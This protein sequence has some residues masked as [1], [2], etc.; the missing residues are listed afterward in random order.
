M[1][2]RS[3]QDTHTTHAHSRTT[4]DSN[5]PPRPLAGPLPRL[6]FYVHLPM[7]TFSVTMTGGSVHPASPLADGQNLVVNDACAP[8][9]GG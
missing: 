7:S 6:H 4:H 9:G 3:L 8:H 5:T 2:K 1:L